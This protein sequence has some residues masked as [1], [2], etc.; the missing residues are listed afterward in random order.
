MN[1]RRRAEDQ[2]DPEPAFGFLDDQ[3]PLEILFVSTRAT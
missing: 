1:F 3:H 2:S